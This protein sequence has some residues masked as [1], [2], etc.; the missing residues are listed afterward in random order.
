MDFIYVTFFF[1]SSQQ[2]EFFIY[3]IRVNLDPKF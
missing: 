2:T 3:A 1:L